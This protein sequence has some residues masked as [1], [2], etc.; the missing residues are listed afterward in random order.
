MLVPARHP[1]LAGRSLHRPPA[2]G[3][4]AGAARGGAGFQ[5]R[6]W[7]GLRLIQI[8]LVCLNLIRHDTG[9]QPVPAYRP[10]TG[11]IKKLHPVC[12]RFSNV[13]TLF[14]SVRTRFSNV[15]TFH[16]MY[17]AS[18]ALNMSSITINVHVCTLYVHVY[19]I[20]N[21]YVNL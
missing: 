1:H 8:K 4:R 13:R 7:Q 15:C 17:D 19:I 12:T 6:C 14:S 3:A 20:Q 21:E 16:E 10:A 9:Q 5:K 2:L 18:C 11:H